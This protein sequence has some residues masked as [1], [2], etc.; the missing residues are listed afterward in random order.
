MVKSDIQQRLEVLIERFRQQ[1]PGSPNDMFY[2][3]VW[4]IYSYSNYLER[5]DQKLKL[6]LGFVDNIIK[7]FWVDD[8]QDFIKGYRCEIITECVTNSHIQSLL[9]LY[10]IDYGYD[11]DA[12]ASQLVKL[13]PSNIF[14]VNS[15]FAV[16][17]SQFENCSIYGIEPDPKQWAV[18]QI[19]LNVI[20]RHD[21]KLYNTSRIDRHFRNFDLIFLNGL[22]HGITDFIGK[23]LKRGGEII[24][25]M[26]KQACIS[27]D[28]KNFRKFLIQNQLLQ[29]ATT[30][31]LCEN[32]Q[33]VLHAY[34][35]K[36]KQ[37]VEKREA[38]SNIWSYNAFV[39]L[40]IIRGD[41]LPKVNPVVL[42][43][44]FLT[45]FL[46]TLLGALCLL[47][48]RTFDIVIAPILSPYS[49]FV[50]FLLSM[51]FGL[52]AKNARSRYISHSVIIFTLSNFSGAT[53]EDWSALAKKV[54]KSEAQNNDSPYHHID[55]IST[56]GMKSPISIS[57][58]KRLFETKT[59]QN[60]S[61]LGYLHHP[62]CRTIS[63]GD[64]V[65][66]E[67]SEESADSIEQTPGSFIFR[68]L[69]LSTDY[70]HC[71]LESRA[72]NDYKY[73]VNK[74]CLL[75]YVDD[76]YIVHIGRTDNEYGTMH[77]MSFYGISTMKLKDDSE[78]IIE[79]DYLL[80]MMTSDF[81]SEQFLWFGKTTK[82]EVLSKI[83]IPCPSMA[84][85][86][87]DLKADAFVLLNNEHV[88]FKKMVEDHKHEVGNQLKFLYDDFGILKDLMDINGELRAH[89]IVDPKKG[90]EVI[91]YF[92][93]ISTTQHSIGEAMERF[94]DDG[95][96]NPTV[97]SLK[98]FVDDYSLTQKTKN[99][100]IEVA[101]PDN[102][103]IFISKPALEK[104]F[105]NIFVN[106][107]KHGF[108][109]P[110]RNDYRIVITAAVKDHITEISISNNGTPLSDGITP[111]SA[112][113]DGQGTG[114]SEHIGCGTIRKICQNY[115]GNAHIE[116]LHTNDGFT[117][118]YILD[119]PN[120]EQ[121]D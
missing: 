93:S 40:R 32:G 104:A 114:K 98:Q 12:F 57:E 4:A 103:Y 2:H 9:S 11:I 110:L 97:F 70:L 105:N 121:N 120:S 113:V 117:V 54:L 119:I 52:G 88:R 17:A 83:Q 13:K 50:M 115:G 29:S 66:F 95:F 15:K 118:R 62:D 25:V 68:R 101:V 82:I 41:F 102:I 106:A 77:P 75:F 1:Y 112:F 21:V 43:F 8:D 91:D 76:A 56:N 38:C 72:L 78:S 63:L 44:L 53:E 80:K 47:L 58:E 99:Y 46:A 100:S 71:S 5:E 107:R 36:D 61:L 42:Y 55:E 27:Q 33:T 111:A 7:P 87:R 28:C 6:S 90:T 48:Y 14:V 79:R 116:E 26:P 69:Q 10:Y 16:I 20:G 109:E 86:N 92:N 94:W 65:D 31:H 34:N 81:V 67:D 3:F 64:L 51:S 59:E 22:C 39:A 96:G 35:I 108:I 85:Q 30:F 18:G 49:I 89:D 23:N 74:N 45:S 60:Y 84:I 19:Y 24:A 37:L 73:H